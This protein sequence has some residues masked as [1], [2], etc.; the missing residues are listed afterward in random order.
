MDWEYREYCLF[1]YM[2]FCYA[3]EYLTLKLIS[4]RVLP[5]YL[6]LDGRGVYHYLSI[7]LDVYLYQYW[8]NDLAHGV[9]IF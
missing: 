5:L 3:F 4:L 8:R 7:D 2:L 1:W 9:V 6:F